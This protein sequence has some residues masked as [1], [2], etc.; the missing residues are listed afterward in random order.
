[1]ESREEFLEES[2]GSE[3]QNHAIHHLEVHLVLNNF[4][5]GYTF[6]SCMNFVL[7]L[8]NIKPEV[9]MFTSATWR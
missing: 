4:V 2:P 8:I 1:M 9:I 5:L 6:P 3:V 7:Y